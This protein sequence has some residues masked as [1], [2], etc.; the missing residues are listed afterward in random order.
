M[1]CS[2]PHLCAPGHGGFSHLLQASEPGCREHPERASPS[3]RLSPGGG[4]A[5]AGLRDEEAA[6]P[7]GRGQRGT[8]AEPEAVAA[9]DKTDNKWVGWENTP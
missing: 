8:G 9:G 5:A 7:G 3:R 4:Q 6:G 2:A 1:T